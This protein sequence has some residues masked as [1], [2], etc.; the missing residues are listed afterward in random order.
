MNN[1]NS[2]HPFLWLLVLAATLFTLL[3]F[4]VSAA[5]GAPDV[6][7]RAATLYEPESGKFLYRKNSTKK[8]PMASTTKIMTAIVASENSSPEELCVIAPEA[9]GVEG[10]SAYLKN[11]DVLSVEELLYALL[12]QSAN[13]AAVALAYHISGSVE[14]F[15]ELMNEKAV[16]LSLSDTHFTN[17][18]GLDDEEHYTTA[19]DLAIIASELLYDPI[20]SKIVST[21][22]KTFI[23]EDRQRTYVNHNKLLKLYDGA[24]GIKTGF[25][26]KSGRCLVGASDK[27]GLRF[28]TVTLDA[29]NDWNDHK[30]L[31]DLGYSTLEKI[32]LAEVGE[33]SYNIPVIG[34]KAEQ[35]TVSNPCE[36]SVIIPKSE[37]NIEKE[38]HLHRYVTAPISKGCKLG[39]IVFK[40]NGKE[41]GR[42]DLIAEADILINKKKS[43]FDILE[44]KFL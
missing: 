17:P 37:H 31:F 12:L 41:L 19:E 43:I 6:S 20:L 18:H 16:E 2:P 3:G 22:K 21:Y 25:T 38:V 23:T 13:D 34:G 28:I 39:E 42:I 35:L 29:P 9:I 11:G 5:N 32:T 15:A 8:L 10:S 26:K 30:K 1:N 14:A 33:F 7:A 24:I 36:L 40:D 27:D 44:M 4:T